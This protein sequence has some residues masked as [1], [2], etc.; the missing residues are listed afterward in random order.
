MPPRVLVT[1]TLDAAAADWLAQ[2]VELIDC[3]FDNQ[4]DLDRLLRHA[5]GLVVRTYTRVNPSLLDKAPNLKVV[6]RAGIGLDNID[7]DAC[8]QRGVTVVYTPDAGTQAVTEYVV[9]LM[10]DALRP[11]TA[12]NGHLSP[13]QFHHLRK[14]EVG[15]QLNE[16]TLGILGF[17]RIG[18]ALGQA[19]CGLAMNVLVND[20][21]PEAQLRKAVDYSYD[22]VDKPTLYRES[23]ILSIHVDGRA[24]NRH[25]IDADA[26]AQLK[27]T[28]VFINT[29]RGMVIDH[30]ALADWVGRHPD[31]KVILDVHDPEP[32][33][34]DYPLYGLSNVRLLPHLASRT[35]TA[36]KNMS[37]VVRDVVAVLEG[38]APRYPAV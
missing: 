12:H 17:G 30:H 36:L 18:K 21:L 11:R 14:T 15:K 27:P 1:E 9:G 32:P 38:K 2:R 28:C 13:E 8:R 4:D 22:F 24:E 20:L 19:A 31:A 29:S 33:P 16:Q 26:L 35:D 37:W 3:P 7:L 5:A 6:G 25:L 10:L 34:P 23:D